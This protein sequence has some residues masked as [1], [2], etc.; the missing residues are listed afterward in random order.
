MGG[1]AEGSEERKGGVMTYTWR[2]G[3]VFRNGNHRWK[4]DSIQGDKAVMRSCGSAW[5]TTIPLTFDEWHENGRW[6]LEPADPIEVDQ[7]I[8]RGMAPR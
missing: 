1:E 8:Q 5:A 7:R 4:V 3:D 6:K 2:I